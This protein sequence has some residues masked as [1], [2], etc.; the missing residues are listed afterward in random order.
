MR[1]VVRNW[2][3]NVEL[4]RLDLIV[5]TKAKA[6][7]R[8]GSWL[9]SMRPQMKS[10]KWICGWLLRWV[11]ML[12]F[13][14]SECGRSQCEAIKF[15]YIIDMVLNALMIIS[16][17]IFI[18][19]FEGILAISQHEVNTTSRVDGGRMAFTTQIYWSGNRQESSSRTRWHWSSQTAHR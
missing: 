19:P 17:P 15:R 2:V 10:I 8:K 11:R 12:L 18:W 7:I 5:V 3:V 16:T 13:H 4:I 14:Y 9:I 6:R 1:I